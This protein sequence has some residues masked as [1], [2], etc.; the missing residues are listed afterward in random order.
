VVAASL[1]RRAAK[2]HILAAVREGK[3]REAAAKAKAREARMFLT[4]A[5][6]AK[7]REP[8]L[9]PLLTAA[10]AVRSDEPYSVQVQRKEFQD[11][12]MD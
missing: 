5:R 3:A 2:T 1:E 11:F 4:A 6:V 8:S 10:R 9:L 12:T 7:A